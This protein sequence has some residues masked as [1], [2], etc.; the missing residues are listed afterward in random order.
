M[1]AR[2]GNDRFPSTQTTTLADVIISTAITGLS[3]LTALTA[4]LVA[5]RF[6]LFTW[7]WWWCAAPLGVAIAT[8]T[9]V[10]TVVLAF[11]RRK[12][13]RPHR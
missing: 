8:S 1:P 13:P 11:R 3:A 9:A 12:D 5:L 7:S 10:G 4:I 6:A 2:H